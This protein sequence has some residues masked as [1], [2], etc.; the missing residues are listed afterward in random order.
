MEK[1]FL[2]EEGELKIPVKI[3]LPESG[4]PRRVVLGVHGLGGSTEDTI[5]QSIAEYFVDAKALGIRP[6]TVHPP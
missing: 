5:Q 6:A 4:A 1:S 3:T 2:L